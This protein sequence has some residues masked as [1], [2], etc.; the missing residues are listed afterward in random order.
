MS[1]DVHLEVPSVEDVY[2][3]N[4][5]HNLG[6]MAAECGIYEALW[7]PERIGIVSAQ[8]LVPYLEKGLAALE[9]DPE[10]YKKFNPANGWG[11]FENLVDFVRTYLAACREHPQATVR[12]S[13]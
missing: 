5:T 2:W 10:R 6:R 4:I 11:N 12:A 8:Q 1:L 13:R 3:R 7:E 9:A